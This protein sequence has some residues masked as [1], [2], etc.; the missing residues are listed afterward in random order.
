MHAQPS[1]FLNDNEMLEMFKCNVSEILNV[2][3]DENYKKQSLPSKEHTLWDEWGTGCTDR[4]CVLMDHTYHEQQC[5][6]VSWWFIG[7]KA[8]MIRKYGITSPKQSNYH[9][10]GEK[11]ISLCSF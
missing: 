2:E 1:K 6:H 7:S 11:L 8:L 4:L 9:S 10:E 3:M 5:S